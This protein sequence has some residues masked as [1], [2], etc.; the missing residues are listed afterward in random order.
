MRNSA[1]LFLSVLLFAVAGCV[2]ERLPS[3]D[4]EVPK[5]NADLILVL[6][7]PRLPANGKEKYE[8]ARKLIRRVDFTFTR[9]TKTLNDILWHGDAIVDFP[10]RPNRTITFNYQYR[11]HYVRLVFHTYLNF[12]F[13]VDV[14]EK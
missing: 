7:N 3:E 8:A 13:R 11:D 6:K 1:V 2:S 5:L 14:I 9:E 10:N 4:I 12:V